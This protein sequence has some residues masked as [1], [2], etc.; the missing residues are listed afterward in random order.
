MVEEMLA[1]QSAKAASTLYFAAIE[2]RTRRDT[3]TPDTRAAFFL[4][5]LASR[6]LTTNEFV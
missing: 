1:E 6:M 3:R 2:S 4:V 5:V